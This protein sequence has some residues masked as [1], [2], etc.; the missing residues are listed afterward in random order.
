MPGSQWTHFFIYFLQSQKKKKLNTVYESHRK[1]FQSKWVMHTKLQ[2]EPATIVVW[3]NGGTDEQDGE[4]LKLLEI[5]RN[6]QPQLNGSFSQ[7]ACNDFPW[8]FY[9]YKTSHILWQNWIWLHFKNSIEAAF[10]FIVTPSASAHQSDTTH[11]QETTPIMK[12]SA[13][14]PAGGAEGVWLQRHTGSF[15]KGCSLVATG[16]KKYDPGM[17][18]GQ[19]DRQ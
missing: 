2:G 1:T 9:I 4:P 18:G 17:G 15:M 13:Q 19:I 6:T 7:R 14:D 3:A 16:R 10:T 12:S 11:A 8:I 5:L